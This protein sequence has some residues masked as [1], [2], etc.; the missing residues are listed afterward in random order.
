M[1]SEQL[2]INQSI[3]T[4]F[5]GL[6][7]DW[8]GRID[9]RYKGGKAPYVNDVALNI[10]KAEKL[11]KYFEDNKSHPNLPAQKHLNTIIT[12]AL[13]RPEYDSRLSILVVNIK[14]VEF[15]YPNGWDKKIAEVSF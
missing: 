14:K 7:G 6:Q 10:E 3:L 1:K 4:S 15:F 11:F 13:E 9:F 8:Y 2:K 12:Y 5:D